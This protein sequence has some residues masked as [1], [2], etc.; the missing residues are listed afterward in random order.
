M[1]L[2]VRNITKTFPGVVALDRVS[3]GFRSGEVHALVGENGAGKSTL[4]KI[5]GGKYQPDAG[6]IFFQG[7]RVRIP[8]PQ[9]AIRMG[10]STVY[11][12]YN[13]IPN[14]KVMDNILLGREPV[15]SMKKIDRKKEQELCRDLMERMNV[16]VDLFKYASE[17]G[18]AE[19]KIVEILKALVAES[20][21]VIMDEPSAALPEHEVEALFRLV[22]SLKRSGVS[23]IYISHRINEIFNIADRVSVLKDG[24]LMGSFQIGE[25]SHDQLIRSMVGRELRD[26]YPVGKEAPS[27]EIILSVQ[28]VGDGARVKNVFFELHR[29]EILGIGGMTGNGQ[30][31]LIRSLF[32]AHS[33]TRGKIL[34]EGTEVA[35]DSPQKALELGISFIPDD[36]RN[37]GLA[38]TQPVRR[39]IALPSL[40]LRQIAGVIQ[41]RGE[42]RS[43][44]DTVRTL[45][46]R[47]TSISQKVS[48]LS[49]GNQQ[50]VVIAKWLPLNPRVLLFHE[51]TLGIDVGAKVEIYRLMRRFTSQGVS[52]IMVTSDMMELLNVPDRILVMY[53][54]SVSAEFERGQATEESVMYAASGGGGSDGG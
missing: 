50:R 36:R 51:P 52:I 49:G 41:G 37:E 9:R 4:I 13:L 33:L 1:L 24:A 3:I 47:V 53:K 54:G 25:I 12:E 46:I 5:I 8:D 7:S 30:R 44:E 39:N 43:V 22:R 45:D 18:A 40:H 35:I 6:E 16:D 2:E 26:T 21:I 14:L 28:G 32:G 17:L 27:E 19:A 34:F 20:V 15:G 29:G 11:Q 10:I 38:V 31:E 42:K 23:V 48:N